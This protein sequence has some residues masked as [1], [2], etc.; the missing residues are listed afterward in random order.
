MFPPNRPQ[1]RPFFPSDKF[2]NPY[3]NLFFDYFR[4]DGKFDFDKVSHS[5]KQVNNIVKQADPLVKQFA[6]FVKKSGKG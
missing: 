3:A 1:R 4:T 6:S 2:R 5:I